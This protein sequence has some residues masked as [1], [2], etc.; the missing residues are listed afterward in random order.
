MIDSMAGAMDFLM[1][2]NRLSSTSLAGDSAGLSIG[3]ADADGPVVADK[4]AVGGPAAADA[5][6]GK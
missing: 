4:A 2:T 5:G 1:I 3:A 6:G